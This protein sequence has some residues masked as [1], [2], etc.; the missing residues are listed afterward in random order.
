MDFSIFIILGALLIVAFWI[1]GIFNKG[2]NSSLAESASDYFSTKI[3]ASK[4]DTL[5]E[6][7]GSLNQADVKIT[8]L[9][10]LSAELRSL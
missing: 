9:S 6:L 10:A 8:E 2:K 5:I 7:Q 3:K 4:A 1:T